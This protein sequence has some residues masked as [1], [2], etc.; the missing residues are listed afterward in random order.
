MTL[1]HYRLLSYSF[2]RQAHIKTNLRYRYLRSP[3]VQS[4]W[5]HIC[6]LSYL[7]YLEEL[8]LI[9]SDD[10]SVDVC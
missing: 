8:G 9:T 2:M 1:N 5:T 4:E 10:V 7:S 6:V 3:L